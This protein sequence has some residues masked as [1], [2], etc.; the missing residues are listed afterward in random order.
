MIPTDV[1]PESGETLGDRPILEP[2]RLSFLDRLR[3]RWHHPLLSR[4]ANFTGHHHWGAKAR[5]NRIRFTVKKWGFQID[6]QFAGR[7]TKLRILR[8]LI[9][10]LIL[11]SSVA[12]VLVGAL[13]T[14]D[15]VIERLV[16]SPHWIQGIAPDF[17]VKIVLEP[18]GRLFD[19]VVTTVAQ[20][21][22]LILGLYFAALGVL[23][24]TVYADVPKSVR[25][26]VLR[27]KVGN[28]Y[29]F[30]VAVLAAVSLLFIALQFFGVQPGFVSLS[31]VVTLSVFTVF[32]FLVVW[33]RVFY[34][35]DPSSLAEE[36]PR[37]I[38]Q[39]LRAA[40]EGQFRFDPSFQNHFRKQA[41]LGLQQF[42]DVVT[43]ATTKIPT[44]GAEIT[45]K[46]SMAALALLEL[47]SQQKAR[48]PSESY[49]FLRIPQHPDWSV[50]NTS[51]VEIALKTGT[52]LQPKMVTDLSWFED[53]AT[54]ILVES[55]SSLLNNNKCAEVVSILE[56][57]CNTLN[58]MAA[59]YCVSDALQVV[60]DV[61]TPVLDWMRGKTVKDFKSYEEW[62][63]VVAMIDAQ[64]LAAISVL[65]GFS[66]SVTSYQPE[67]IET[68]IAAISWDDQRSVYSR[69]VPRS[70][71][72][73]LEFLEKRLGFELDVEG[74]T[75]SPPWYLAQI[76]ALGHAQYV[77]NGLEALIDEF[78]RNF[79]DSVQILVEEQKYLLAGHHIQRGLEACQ[80]FEVHAEAIGD[81]LAKMERLRRVT[82][83]PWPVVDWDKLKQRQASLQQFLVEI[84]AEIAIDLSSLDL[85]DYLPDYAGFAYARLANETYV[86]ISNGDDNLLKRLFPKLF[87]L[88]LNEHD[89]LR[90]KLKDRG[91]TNRPHLALT[92]DHLVD[93]MALSGLAVVWGELE[94]RETWSV[95][96][97]T[98]NDYFQH[99]S[100]AKDAIPF[101]FSL[102]SFRGRLNM[103][104][105]SRSMTRTSWKIGFEQEMRRRGLLGWDVP[106]Q[107]SDECEK[108]HPSPLIRTLMDGNSFSYDFSDIF[109]AWYL[110]ERNEAAGIKQPHRVENL[111]NSLKRESASPTPPGE[112]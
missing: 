9:G 102:I 36:L 95:V 106:F 20:V 31:F 87:V 8:S 79:R 45:S 63:P 15:H 73:Q 89:R 13:L 112:Q 32:G 91:L 74:H 33:Q 77:R 108:K 93:L 1:T 107:R 52:F 97:N 85:P 88:G 92:T 75:Q 60:R 55:V 71:V 86:A 69:N 37:P 6:H 81:A 46:P 101:F 38:Y 14:I 111:L 10:S 56:G 51:A 21:S 11:K 110:A 35:F 100:N 16:S 48:I 4:F 53:A 61:R 28:V 98:W 67:D 22:G 59:N 44:Q 65:L 99:S 80:K 39:W 23:I 26:I 84:L 103:A 76:A 94:N 17:L 2:P 83:I 12:V 64:G 54:A 3:Q 30:W 57:I 82:D 43:F 19:L 90:K 104:L 62:S 24:G 105:S 42:R 29:I 109:A 40:S 70:V 68:T 18:D 96:E 58:E 78:D 5:Y 41:A 7:R 50:A 34:L 72:E 66:R 25:Q 27:E 47:Y 49:W